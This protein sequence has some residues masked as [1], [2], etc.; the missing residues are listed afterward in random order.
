[1][2]LALDD[3]VLTCCTVIQD[4]DRVENVKPRPRNI[5]PLADVKELAKTGELE[6]GFTEKMAHSEANRC[7]QCGLICYER[8]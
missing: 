4:V 5:M 1:M 3:A 7:L 6:K 8:S 2:P